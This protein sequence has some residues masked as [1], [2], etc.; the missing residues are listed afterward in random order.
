MTV[1]ELMSDLSC[2]EPDDKVML[3]DVNG[4][5]YDIDFT[6]TEHLDDIETDTVLLAAGQ[7]QGGGYEDTEID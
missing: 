7:L 4:F 3:Q 2:Y 1:K 6:Y 5:I